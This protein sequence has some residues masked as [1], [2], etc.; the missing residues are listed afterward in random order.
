MD[1]RQ[2]K[3][4]LSVGICAK[5]ISMPKL[6]SIKTIKQWK[7]HRGPEST[8]FICLKIEAPTKF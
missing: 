2:K 4:S 3:V 7:I 8:Y 6:Q 5:F 1:A